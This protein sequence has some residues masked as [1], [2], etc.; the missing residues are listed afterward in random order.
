LA[1]S[2][3][4]AKR[5][6]KRSGCR[7]LQAGTCFP[8]FKTANVR[9]DSAAPKSIGVLDIRSYP[10]VV[11]SSRR[12]RLSVFCDALRTKLVEKHAVIEGQKKLTHFGRLAAD[13]AHEVRN[14]LAAI[15]YRVF[16]LQKVL[17]RRS[18]EHHDAE[19]IRAAIDRLDRIV[20][21]FF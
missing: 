14:P 9:I 2:G 18:A 1:L 17:A 3:A 5:R 20:K 7:R 10:R 13:L 21:E 4:S 12:G 16:A 6:P 19:V 8:A 15:N 11:R